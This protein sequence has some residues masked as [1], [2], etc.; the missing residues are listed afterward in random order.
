MKPITRRQAIVWSGTALAAPQL[1]MAQTW[2]SRPIRL[3]V[4]FPP[5][6]LIDNMARLV[7]SRLAQELGQAVV[8][9]NKPGAGG[10]VG[11]AEVAR[12][13]ADGYT[14]L[15]ASPPLTISP[16][17]YAS[18]PYKPEQLA[19]VALLGRVPNVLVVNP[20][21]GIGSVADLLARA[22]REPG[23]L[24]YASNGNGTSLHLSAEL[25]K[26]TSG[27]FVTHIP[28]R[29][30]AAA[31]TGLIAGEVEMMFENLPSVLGQIQGGT[32][33]ALAV[34]TL[35]R[36]KTLPDVPTLVELG[37]PEFDVS[38]WYGVAAP[39]GTPPAV[40]SAL[41][42]ALQKIMREPEVIRAME[43]RGAEVG[44]MP[45]ADMGAFMA[46]DAQ[47]WKRVASFAKI[48]LG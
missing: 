4:P 28:Y 24:N 10:N 31:V 16:A 13:P 18:L 22:K 14:L 7:G 6:G 23:K 30:A 1:A 3:V 8:I 36:S 41:E 17:L 33:K 11:A 46:A 48:T 27:T 32:V 19:P 20:K 15:M 25:F 44:F 29:G 2:P 42:Q 34:T 37:M 9:D 45:A 35:R 38:A 43:S 5:G 47:K 40:V 21:S 26:S 12:S 39:A